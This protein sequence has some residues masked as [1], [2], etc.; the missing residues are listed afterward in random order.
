MPRGLAAGAPNGVLLRTA[1]RMKILVVDDEPVSRSLMQHLLQG[2]G[3]CE[4]AATGKEAV[5]AFAKAW[6]DWAPFDIITLDISMPDM[7]G[8]EVLSLIR[9]M[10]AR[11]NVPEAHRV[12]II[13]VTARSDK[14]TVI[15][16]LRVGCDDYVTKPF[17]RETI[18]RKVLKLSQPSARW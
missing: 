4:T 8:T 2:F 17:Y 5:A 6:Q 12:K 3:E 11:K 13:M 10:E 16:A 7:D 14:R 18:S 9:D 15:Q 1:T